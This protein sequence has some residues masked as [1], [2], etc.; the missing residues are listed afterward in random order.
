MVYISCIRICYSV[1]KLSFGGECTY[2]LPV[3]WQGILKV[4]NLAGNVISHG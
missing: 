2:G 4:G 3:I 1:N